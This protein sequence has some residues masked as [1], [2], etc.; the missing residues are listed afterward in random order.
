MIDI[1]LTHP[2]ISHKN[3]ICKWKQ[4]NNCTN[5]FARLLKSFLSFHIKI[6]KL[7]WKAPIKIIKY[8][9]WIKKQIVHILY[10][11]ILH[12]SE[13]YIK[14]MKILGKQWKILEMPNKKKQQHKMKIAVS[15]T[16]VE[17]QNGKAFK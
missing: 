13:G 15:W 16:S 11:A 9:Q 1:I 10:S 4:I 17:I 5:I 7:M 6:Y 12:S 2:V 14:L 8:I 3:T